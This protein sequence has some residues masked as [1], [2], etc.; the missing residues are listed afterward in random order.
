MRLINTTTLGLE[1]FFGSKFP[2][3]AILSHTWDTEEV[4]YQDWSNLHTASKL[5]GYEKIV[6]T[7]L[8][9]KKDGYAYVWVDTNCTI[10][11][12]HRRQ[13]PTK[14]VAYAA[15]DGGGMYIAFKY[16]PSNI[17]LFSYLSQEN[18]CP[19]CNPQPDHA[20]RSQNQDPHSEWLRV[21][22]HILNG[23]EPT[24]QCL[25]RARAGLIMPEQNMSR[26]DLPERNVSRSRFGAPSLKGP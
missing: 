19:P 1:N 4:T 26:L 14:R 17:S 8:L 2:K 9:A 3:Y 10:Q 20:T 6:S 16:K 15:E 21:T 12:H 11:T 23:Y 13:R 24:G 25:S 22:D 18:P 5:K 7:C